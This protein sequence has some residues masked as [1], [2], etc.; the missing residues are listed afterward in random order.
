MNNIFILSCIITLSLGWTVTLGNQC[1][2]SDYVFQNDC[3]LAY[4]YGCIWN[5]ASSTCSNL[6]CSD[7]IVDCPIATTLCAYNPPTDTCGTFSSCS[8]LSGTSVQAC[9]IQNIH[10]TW[11]SGSNCADFNCSKFSTSNCPQECQKTQTAC[12][13][14]QCQTLSMKQCAEVEAFTIYPICKVAGP[15]TCR[16]FV[17]TDFTTQDDCFVAYNS[18]KTIQP[19]VWSTTCVDAQGPT[20]YTAATCFTSTLG[21]Y[22]WSSSSATSGSCEQCTGG[23]NGSYGMLL[24]VLFAIILLLV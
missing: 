13:D 12:V 6:K 2:C 8:S 17:C 4:V 18:G 20:G 11:V 7:Y 9:A 5:D 14:Y 3:V 10:C 1:K 21:Q 24:Q 16:S 23:G 19:C 15:T 22:R